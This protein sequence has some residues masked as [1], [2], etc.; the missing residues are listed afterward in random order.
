ML[1][2][3]NIFNGTKGLYIGLWKPG[4]QDPTDSNMIKIPEIIK[5]LKKKMLILY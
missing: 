2:N 3:E 1:L 5:S 4:L